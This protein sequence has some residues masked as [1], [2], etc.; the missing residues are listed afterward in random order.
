VGRLLFAVNAS[1][2]V[3]LC[4]WV[5]SCMSI[6]VFFLHDGDWG[7]SMPI[8]LLC[9]CVAVGEAGVAVR[10]GGGRTLCGDE[11][12]AGGCI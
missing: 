1:V 10:S 11:T 2:R 3:L 5:H 7:G 8:D 4:V 6:C 12:Q 9:V